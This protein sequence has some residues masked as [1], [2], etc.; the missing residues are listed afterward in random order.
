MI[1]SYT[2]A[3]TPGKFKVFKADKFEGAIIAKDQVP[4][5]K[6]FSERAKE[7][8]TPSEQDVLKADDLA[9]VYLQKYKGN[10]QYA[11]ASIPSILG[12]LN[13]YKRQYVGFIEESG[14]KTIWINYFYD[15]GN[16]SY[17]TENLVFVFDGGSS[18]F[19]IKVNLKKKECYDLSINGVA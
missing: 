9:K 5:L 13:N 10:D 17:W 18:F 11:K 4:Q 16:F 19:R 12:R 1:T 8:W 6:Y 7:Y 14:D 3:Q 2:F 15:S